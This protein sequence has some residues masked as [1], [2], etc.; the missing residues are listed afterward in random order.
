MSTTQIHLLDPCAGMVLVVGSDGTRLLY[1]SQAG[2]GSSNELLQ[3]LFEVLEDGKIDYFVHPGIETD[4]AVSV[5]DI[6]DMFPVGT[7]LEPAGDGFAVSQRYANFRGDREVDTLEPDDVYE[8]G[9]TQVR[10]VASPHGRDTA[11]GRLRPVALHVVHGEGATG[12]GLLCTGA[13]N[14][15][16]WLDL[17]EDVV[18][19][20]QAD[21]LI[22]DGR[23]P[24]DIILTAR[25][26]GLVSA[27][28]LRW[29]APR[30]VLLGADPDGENKL[31][32]AARELFT[33]IARQNGGGA[34]LVELSSK[35]WTGLTLDGT[36][37][38]IDT[39]ARALGKVA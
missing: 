10:I 4:G 20:F 37:A 3:R 24:L 12:G 7:C 13:M 35:A 11:E 19:Q 25:D 33:H 2:L 14:G 32:V 5:S 39:E 16:D 29:I 28:P 22:V 30:T 34:G 26:R 36:A 21:A 38:A 15:L 1:G 27:D 8:L 17:G 23:H 18:R 31:R 9:D 6:T